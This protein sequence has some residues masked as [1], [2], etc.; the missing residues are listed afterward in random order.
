MKGCRGGGSPTVDVDN[1][2]PPVHEICELGIDFINRF[3]EEQ[4]SHLRSR[5]PTPSFKSRVLHRI[6]WEEAVFAG[7]WPCRLVINSPMV[8]FFF[9]LRTFYGGSEATWAPVN[10]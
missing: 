5:H 4:S 8:K 9:P 6:F 7:A 2:Q 3:R 1:K 10:Q